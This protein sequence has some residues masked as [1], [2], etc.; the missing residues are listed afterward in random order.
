MGHSTAPI[1]SRHF[2]NAL[3]AFATGVTVVTTRDVD[4]GDIGL[5]ASSFNS[6][7][8]EPPLILWSLA[9]NA[10]S[11]PAFMACEYFAVH[12]LSVAQQELSDRFSRKGADKFASIPAQRGPA[13]IPLLADC[14]ARFICKMTYRYEGGDHIILVGEVIEFEHSGQAPLLFHSGKYGRV[15]PKLASPNTPDA[16][17][18]ISEYLGLLLGR[19]A[20]QLYQPAKKSWLELGLT[21]SGYFVL[22]ALASAE[23]RPQSSVAELIGLGGFSLTEQVLAPLAAQGLL[24]IADTDAEPALKLT[25]AGLDMVIQLAAQ[26]RSAEE[27][28]MVDM[29]L[30]DR[31]LFKRLLKKICRNSAP[32]TAM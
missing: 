20:L 3:G 7:S 26:A 23:P 16:D 11:L 6:V 21:E 13:G 15:L 32:G 30:E 27:L 14:T 12:V 31:L 5:T 22:M 8:L 19:A 28:A 2:R 25:A 29:D 4:G 1:D 18:D 24:E 10:A 17:D 9:R